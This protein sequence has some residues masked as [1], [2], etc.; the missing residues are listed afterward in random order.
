[1]TLSSNSPLSVKLN[2]ELWVGGRI[3][4]SH[5]YMNIPHSISFE[6]ITFG[7]LLSLIKHFSRMEIQQKDVWQKESWVPSDIIMYEMDMFFWQ[8]RIFMSREAELCFLHGEGD[9]MNW[10]MVANW[11][12]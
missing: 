11:N 9:I 6:F 3:I 8:R 10:P 7:G 4:I 1:M 2:L 12:R 5:I